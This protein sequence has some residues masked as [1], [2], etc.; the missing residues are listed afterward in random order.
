[1]TAQLPYDE[2]LQNGKGG[3]ITSVCWGNK[4]GNE[5]LTGHDDGAV[6][7]WAVSSGGT[8]QFLETYS[9]VPADGQPR[10]PI[11]S[12]DCLFGDTPM[13]VVRGGNLAGVPQ[14]LSLIKPQPSQGGKDM[15]PI[16]SHVPWFGTLQV[17]LQPCRSFF[18]V[19]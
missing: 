10:D 18:K 19:R 6:L 11:T 7:R 16:V 15:P 5:V 8:L 13:V 12:V 3:G 9:V 4:Q 1:M 14:S 2:A 17:R